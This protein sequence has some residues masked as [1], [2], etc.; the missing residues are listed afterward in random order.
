LRRGRLP[1]GVS[2]PVPLF[3]SSLPLAEPSP[4][5]VAIARVETNLLGSDEGREWVELFN[6]GAFDVEVGD[7]GLWL[8][9]RGPESRRRF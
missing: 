8:P 1:R 4:P 6:N 9:G 2:P 7:G 5:A 3:C